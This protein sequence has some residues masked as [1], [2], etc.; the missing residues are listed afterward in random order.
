[1]PEL[2]PVGLVHGTYI[3]CENEKGMYLIDQHAAQERI[4]YEK[5]SYY[6]SH[7]KDNIT[8]MIVPIV[9]DLPTN[10]FLIIKK[11]IDIIKNL[12]IDIEEFGT[13]S[14]RITSHPTWFPK[15][16]TD[17]VIRNIFEQVIKEEKDFNLAKFNDHL[18]ATMACKAS[19][20]GNTRITI[21]DMESIINQLRECNNPFN[22]PHG[23]PTIIEFTTYELEKMFKRSV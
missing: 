13:N 3:I 2:Y 8:S 15:S 7:P 23:R 14:Y 16:T 21:N 20:K 6:L 4:N 9:I 19:V 22:C 5:Y 18:A 17:K 12:N 1:M 10:E 11:N